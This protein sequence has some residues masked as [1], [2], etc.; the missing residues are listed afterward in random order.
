MSR[1]TILLVL[2]LAFGA[3]LLAAAPTESIAKGDTDW[4][5]SHSGDGLTI[6]SRAH[7]GSSLKEFKAVGEIDASSRSVFGVIADYE[8]YPSFMPYTVEC[9]L[10]KKESDSYVTYQRIAP[11]VCSDRDYA[12]R[13]SPSSSPGPEGTVYTNKWAT[14]NDLAPPPRTDVT[15]VQVCE[16]SWLLEPAG[17]GKTRATYTIYSDTGGMVPTFLANH[18]AQTGIVKVF[19]AI[20]TQVKNPKYNTPEKS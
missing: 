20:K 15:R 1:S 11:K 16:G 13:V 19:A 7:P 12:V 9:R 14:A 4:K 10:L 5:L 2:A 18:F 8:A 6:Y 3:R 17:R